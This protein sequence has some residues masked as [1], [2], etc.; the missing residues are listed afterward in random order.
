MRKPCWLAMAVALS[1]LSLADAETVVV[2]REY[3]KLRKGPGS[4]YEV[5]GL[6]RKGAALAIDGKD[7]QGRWLK[8][9]GVFAKSAEEGDKLVAVEPA[10]AG[11][12]TWIAR[13]AA[14]K[15][16]SEAEVARVAGTPDA[17][18]VDEALSAASIRGM[19]DDV[20]KL[21]AYNHADPELAAW[22]LKPRFAPAAYIQFRAA[23]LPPSGFISLALTDEVAE[24]TMNVL[25]ADKLGIMVAAK[26]AAAM[27]GRVV[28]DE[29]LNGYVSM[30]ATLV[31]EAT[32]GYDVTYRVVIVDEKAINSFS[33]P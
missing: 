30:V 27:K 18:K 6:V 20:E 29:T 33:T 32:A 13:I 15:S 26:L 1:A 7:E 22:M 19:D 17:I 16:Q 5:A 3:A 24:E 8:V 11:E 9:A 25:G 12:E 14:S 23:T 31:G 21:L 2:E 28:R 4:F 10:K